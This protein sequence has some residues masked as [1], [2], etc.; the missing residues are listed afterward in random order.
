MRQSLPAF[1]A[2]LLLA[3]SFATLHAAPAVTRTPDAYG[4]LAFRAIGPA[5]GGRISRVAG[6]PGNPDVYYFAAAQG[7]VWASS[8]AGKSFS[9]VM[10]DE[11]LAASMGAIA[12]APSDPNVIYAGG[13]EANPRGNVMVGWGIWKSTDAGK[14]WTHQWKNKGQ[15]GT[16]AVDPHNADVAYAAVLGSPFGA[17]QARGVYRTQDGGKNW[18]RV[19]FKDIDTGASD[20][21]ID[22]HNPRIVFA[23][24]WQMRRKPWELTSGGPGSGLY[25]STDGGDTWA[26]LSGKGLPEGIW[27]KVGVRV[28]P[29][30]GQRV[31]ALIEAENGGL[32]RS[33]DGGDTWRLINPQR[34]LRQRAWY[35]T[36]FTIDPKDPDTLWFP[37]VPLLRST[38]GGKTVT[39]VPGPHHGDH[40]DLWI[41]P[42]DTRRVI[43][44]HDGG[45]DISTDGGKTWSH[46][47]LPL[48]QFYN[49]DVDDRMPWRVGG[50][51]QDWGTASGPNMLPKHGG[52][53]LPDWVG[54]GGGEAGDF[55]YDALKPGRIYAG[56]YG[57]YLSEYDEGTGQYRA[58]HIDPINLSGLHGKD[59]KYRFQWTAPFEI[60]PHD[61]AVLYHGGNLLFR[62]AD[63][64]AS[65]QA[66]SPDL[67][68]NEKATQGWSGGPITGDITGVETYGTIFSIR[69]SPREA[70]HIWAGTDDGRV[71]LTR[72][73]GANWADV[74]PRGMPEWGTV[75]HI[76][77]SP[78]QDGTAWAVVEA[79]R[80]D[81]QRPWLFRT[82][83]YGAS[84]QQLTGDLP[85][86]QPL[87]VLRE[88][89]ED[90]QLLYLGGERGL[91][92][93]RNGG[94]HWE[95][96]AQGL[97]PVAVADIEIRHGALVLGT[98]RGIWALDDLQILR[99][100]GDALARE[101]LH[102]FPSQPATRWQMDHSWGEQGAMPAPPYGLRFAYFLQNEAKGDIRAEILNAKGEVIR[103]LSSVLEPLK[104]PVDDPDSPDAEAYATE[105]PEPALSR[106]AGINTAVWDLRMAGARRIASK[107]DAGNPEEGPLVA[108]GTY[109]LR[110]VVGAETREQDIEVLPDPRSPATPEQ[111]QANVDF[112]VAARDAMDR[113]LRNVEMLQAVRAQAKDVM[114]RSAG[115]SPVVASATA[116]EER[117]RA[118]EYDL[119]NPDAEVFYDVLTGRDGGAK[120]YGQFALLPDLAQDADYPP[121]Q[122]I[123]ERMEELLGRLAEIEAGVE[124]MRAKELAAFEQAVAAAALPRVI[125]PR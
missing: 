66:I 23:G 61:P 87:F 46:P 40:H 86:D 91:W 77:V 39:Q 80:L 108:P 4:A 50:T 49:I 5:I 42:L 30:D 117:A 34:A 6:V 72:D 98:R 125:L 111:L 12:V 113:V 116:L 79:R 68:R 70:G 106:D 52:V 29:S 53:V 73:G 63:R 18:V 28:A 56:E 107:V 55:R 96:V 22:E 8:D 7:G 15:I 37:Q 10:D 121:S 67:S 16:L 45:V 44:G 2:S 78:H 47:D 114:A 112:A 21:A 11:A 89:P 17:A 1:C 90:P 20:V 120:L 119:H 13:G 60:S 33:D 3:S 100:A 69:E 76:E 54:A 102:L 122:G 92:L 85:Q 84:W 31:Y 75:E 32:F 57:G 9:P 99:T 94:S 105:S 27:G 123:R 118:L 71:Q 110:L 64:G 82:T 62:S 38:D 25:R 81:D 59:L 101:T 93:S 43:A 124:T 83:N 88:D 41:D 95:R 14:T 19:L 36:T 58:L 104:Y 48:G 24:F 51:I 97:P 35:Y 115:V 109:R 65:W 103:T 26:P 74:T